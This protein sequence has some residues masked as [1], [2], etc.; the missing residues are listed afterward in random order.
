MQSKK[1]EIVKLKANYKE[2]KAETSKEEQLAKQLKDDEFVQKYARAKYH[3]SNSG[4]VTFI[5]PE[6]VPQ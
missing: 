6:L 2:T 1:A 4:E 3:Y 5:I